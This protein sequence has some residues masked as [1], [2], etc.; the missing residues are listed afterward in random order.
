MKK[1]YPYA[2]TGVAIIISTF[3]W[4]YIN[5]AYDHKNIIRG[6]YFEKKFNPLNDTIRGI[7]FISFP[8]FIYLISFL[9]FN[10]SLDI[11]KD[12]KNYFLRRS[13]EK[14]Y[15]SLHLDFISLILVIFII[16]EFLLLNVDTYLGK[17][18]THHEGTFLVAPLNFIYKDQVWLG[19]FFD[20]GAIGNNIGIIFSKIFGNYSIG[21]IR[22][23]Q[24]FF[25]LINK[26][27]LI[28]IC[29]K[30]VMNLSLNKN[31][32]FFFIIL[33]ILSLSLATYHYAQVTPFHPRVFLYLIF[34]L[35]LIEILTSNRPR[36]LMAF[37][38]GFFSLFSVLWYV[39]FGAY[40]NATLLIAITFLFYYQNYLNAIIIIFGVLAS[41]SLFFIILP[42]NETSE[43][44]FQFNFLTKISGYLLGLEFPKPFSNGATRHTK[45]LLFIIISGIFLINFLLNKRL[46]INS[47]TKIILLF[48]FISS[49]LLF[50]S[51][52]MRS[53]GPHIKYSSG[54]YMLFIFFS[55]TY[56]F[57]LIISKNNFLEKILIQKKFNYLILVFLGLFI[58]LNN[59][60]LNGK[61]IFNEKKNIYLL[62]KIDDEFFLKDN[63]SIFIKRFKE[64]S[65]KDVCVQQFSDDNAL[66]Y[67]INK[68]TCTQFYVNSHIISGWTENIFIKQ[69]KETKPTFI[70][71]TSDINWFKGKKN[72]PNA[73]NFI[74]SNYSLYE[75]IDSWE[76][77]KINNESY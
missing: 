68:P 12:K 34:F 13:D 59:N 36:P 1:F 66:P 37:F 27:L 60:L 5:F 44:F 10:E 18:D 64:M 69:L 35:F 54:F 16:V 32:E 41:W 31:S 46:L 77:Y 28:L 75:K 29:R 51:G 3:F 20:Y 19:T 47:R 76:I 23:A 45:A 74:L 42:S 48:I 22:F 62:T 71:Y 7:F 4:D 30:I 55:I 73:D 9:Q 53:D 58:I 49:I 57:H 11:L 50:K 52:L 61:N 25:V 39:D 65:N 38:L 63:Y 24:I 21:I 67:F 17:I 70:V 15:K 43:F 6:E 26:I 72:A 33:S 40:T 2:F 14:V 56:F 8:L